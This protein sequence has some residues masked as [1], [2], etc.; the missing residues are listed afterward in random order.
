MIQ[1]RVTLHLFLLCVFVTSS[2]LLSEAQMTAE[3]VPSCLES[4]FLCDNKCLVALSKCDGIH[5]CADGVDERNCPLGKNHIYFKVVP[6]KQ[7]FSGIQLR[8]Q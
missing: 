7:I 5:D 4:E 3:E 1:Q 2:L 8:Q 6:N